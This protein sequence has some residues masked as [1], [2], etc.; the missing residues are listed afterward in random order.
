MSERTQK[1]KMDTVALENIFDIHDF[2]ENDPWLGI[3]TSELETQMNQSI[4]NLPPK[5][6][7]IFI[8]QRRGFALQGGS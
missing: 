2:P 6:R 8:G 3:V 1:E 4:E 5:C 7:E